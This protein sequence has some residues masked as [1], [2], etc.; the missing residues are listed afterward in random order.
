MKQR[1]LFRLSAASIAVIAAFPGLAAEEAAEP[2]PGALSVD[3]RIGLGHASSDGRYFGQYT[4]VNERGFYGLFDV[5][6][7]R[8]DEKTG[9]WLK[10][11]G[12]N[13]GLDSRQLRLEHNRQGNWGYFI[14]YSGI[15]RY[16]PLRI[17]TAVSGIGSPNLAIPAPAS[18]GFPLNLDTRR[19]VLGLGFEKMF[20][21]NWDMSVRFRNDEKDGARVFARGTT[22]GAPAGFFGNFEFTP[23]PINSTT[24]QL[25][26]LLNYTG[27]K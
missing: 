23:E 26:V 12:R 10:F 21:G 19:D 9:T 22:G 3:A 7:A 4:G 24:R 27:E 17:T 5:S 18:P 8:R 13:L 1:D 16:E 14:E 15:P 20:W 6:A 11:D 2:A 25:D